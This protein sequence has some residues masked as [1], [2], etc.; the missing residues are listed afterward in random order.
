LFH[1]IKYKEH[2]DFKYKTA[3]F[4]FKIK[5]SDSIKIRGLNSLNSFFILTADILSGSDDD[6]D[7]HLRCYIND[8]ILETKILILQESVISESTSMWIIA[9]M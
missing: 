9:T 7:I 2:L 1:N 4:G 3:L 8:C 5:Y 6:D